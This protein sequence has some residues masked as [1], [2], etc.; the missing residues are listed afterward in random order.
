MK[1]LRNHCRRPARAALFFSACS[2]SR[3][4]LIA[5][6]VPNI[7]LAVIWFDAIE[8]SLAV[9]AVVPVNDDCDCCCAD[10]IDA[11]GDDDSECDT[12]AD[13]ESPLALVFFPYAFVYGV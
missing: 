6:T 1:N 11:D 7:T 9:P 5:P 13:D 10:D 4:S 12:L 3:S 8:A 2:F